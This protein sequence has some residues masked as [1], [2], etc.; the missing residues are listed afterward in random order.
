[1]R[2]K[3]IIKYYYEVVRYTWYSLYVFIYRFGEEVIRR[4]SILFVISLAGIKKLLKLNNFIG[5]CFLCKQLDSAPVFWSW[6][7]HGNIFAYTFDV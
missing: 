4:S 7:Y 1:M 6:K 5:V 3:V 2:F